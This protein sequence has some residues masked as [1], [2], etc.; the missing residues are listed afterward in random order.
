MD[1]MF[2]NAS[3]FNQDISGWVVSSVNSMSDMFANIAL[4]N[5]DISSWD[6]SSVTAMDGMFRNTSSFDQD[7]SDWDISSIIT[8]D[9]M[10]GEGT[11]MSTVNMDASLNGWATLDTIAGETA[12]NNNVLLTTDNASDATA[13]QH[14]IDTYNWSVTGGFTGVTVGSNAGADTVTLNAAGETYHGLGGNDII[15]GGAGNDIIFGG[16]GD[17]T[18][19]GGGGVNTFDYGHTDAGN[20]TIMD[21]TTGMGADILDLSDLL[22]GYSVGDISNWVTSTSA[23][24]G[25][26]TILTIYHDGTGSASDVDV[27]T[28]TLM[29]VAYAADIED[30]LRTDGNIIF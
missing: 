12:I 20:D 6:V 24:G 26:D 23:G 19:A 18:L 27:V 29:G 3:A 30:T 11:S 13:V 25:A 8:M 28:I 7:L 1:D 14:L 10:F 2:F 16:T 22:I 4:F 21:F 5:Q 15:T 9:N 17:D